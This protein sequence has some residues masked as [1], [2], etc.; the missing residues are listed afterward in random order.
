MAPSANDVLRAV[1]RSGVKYQ[2][3]DGWDNPKIQASGH[4]EPEYVIQH[5][6]ANGGAKGNAPSLN[7]M[8][9]DPYFP[10]RACHFMIARDGL[11][12]VVYALKCYHAGAG[13]PGRW[14]DGPTVPKD[15]MNGYA[16]G[17][18]IE[19]K[20]MTL[21]TTKSSGTDG[22]TPAQYASLAYLNAALLDLI[23]AS[24]VGRII[25]HRTW[26]PT[27]KV[28]TRDTDQHLQAITAVAR[29]RLNGTGGGGLGASAPAHAAKPTK[30]STRVI[31]ATVARK[32]P[33]IG[34]PHAGG[35]RKPGFTVRY[36]AV[37]RGGGETW[38]RT[39]WGNFYLA[40]RT[41]RGE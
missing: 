39:R 30:G 13:G 32:A 4:W 9:H 14:G 25:N 19:S 40:K 16:Y 18:E 33:S 21:D 6:T 20:G 34:S 27:R 8:V 7:W 17:I 26:A 2:L 28:D 10:I 11:V 1:K 23:G 41:A 12:Y 36:V 37:V 31:E 3:V 38:L 24:S 22:I 29:R 15:S 5:H 35:E